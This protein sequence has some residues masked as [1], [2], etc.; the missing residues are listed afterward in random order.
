M[1][2]FELEKIAVEDIKTALEYIGKTARARNIFLGNK[3]KKQ[4][5]DSLYPLL[6]HK[7]PNNPKQLTESKPCL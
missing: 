3:S 5:T 1:R 2:D 7:N 6:T 4:K